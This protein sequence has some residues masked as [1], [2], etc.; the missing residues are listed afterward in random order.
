MIGSGAGHLTA[1]I[2]ATA[3]ATPAL[4][5]YGNAGRNLMHGPPHVRDGSIDS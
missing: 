5:N 4:Y 1:C 2:D 3:F